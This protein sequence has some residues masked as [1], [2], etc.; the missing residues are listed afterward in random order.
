MASLAGR[1]P[2]RAQPSCHASHHFCNGRGAFRA[3]EVSSRSQPRP[4]LEPPYLLQVPVEGGPPRDEGARGVASGLRPS[5]AIVHRGSESPC[6]PSQGHTQRRATKRRR[7]ARLG[8]RRAQRRLRL[9]LGHGLDMLP[10]SRQR[11]RQVVLGYRACPIDLRHTCQGTRRTGMLPT[12]TGRPR[13]R[14]AMTFL[15]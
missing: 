5:T 10:P 9:P 13:C 12:P 15:T 7:R 6:P 11:R 8:L 3:G 4:G 14:C 1:R 2:K